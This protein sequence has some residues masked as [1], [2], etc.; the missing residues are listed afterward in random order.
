MFYIHNLSQFCASRETAAKGC[1]GKRVSPSL[2]A[3]SGQDILLVHFVYKEKKWHILPQP[4]LSTK[5]S[6]DLYFEL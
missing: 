4:N 3:L 1:V 5:D 6:L 2:Y